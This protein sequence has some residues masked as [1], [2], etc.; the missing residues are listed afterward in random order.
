MAKGGL[1]FENGSNVVVHPTAASSI[2]ITFASVVERGSD[3]RCSPFAHQRTRSGPAHRAER[4]VAGSD[5]TSIET[6]TDPILEQRMARSGSWVPMH[7]RKRFSRGTEKAVW[8]TITDPQLN[9]NALPAFRRIRSVH[10]DSASSRDSVSY[11][12]VHALDDRLEWEPF[13]SGRAPLTYP[14]FIA[15]ADN[16]WMWGYT[17]FCISTNPGSTNAGKKSSCFRALR[18][19]GAAEGIDGPRVLPGRG[20]VNPAALSITTGKMGVRKR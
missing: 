14:W 9:T 20:S 13:A 1:W 8:K 11:E 10:L 18:S 16:F 2:R 12:L 19:M 5:S 3:A 4:F 7:T 15:T 17:G 6:V